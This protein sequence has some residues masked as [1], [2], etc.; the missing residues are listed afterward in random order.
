MPTEQYERPY[1]LALRYIYLIREQVSHQLTDPTYLSTLVT[2]VVKGHEGAA[3]DFW[4]KKREDFTPDMDAFIKTQGQRGEAI[5]AGD[6]HVGYYKDEKG[7]EYQAR[8]YRDVVSEACISIMSIILLRWRNRFF[9]YSAFMD[10]CIEEVLEILQNVKNST[11]N[12]EE[13]RERQRKWFERAREGFFKRYPE[14]EIAAKVS[15]YYAWITEQETIEGYLAVAYDRQS[16]YHW[17]W[18]E[19]L[20][21]K[22][23]QWPEM[24]GEIYDRKSA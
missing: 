16:A 7:R 6:M 10:L 3:R 23:L 20:S 21:L 13:L 19:L 17:M 9:Y 12:R 2:A 5:Y 15:G 8:L 4:T 14:E 1:A 24:K 18:G 11:E 22:E